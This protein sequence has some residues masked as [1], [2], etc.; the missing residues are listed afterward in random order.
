MAKPDERKG[1][2]TESTDAFPE[3]EQLNPPPDNSDWTNSIPRENPAL[4]EKRG[5]FWSFLRL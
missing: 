3:A 1:K 5:G 2:E 4:K